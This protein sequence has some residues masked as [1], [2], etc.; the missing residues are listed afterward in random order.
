LLAREG[1]MPQVA[2][3]YQAERE[4]WRPQAPTMWQTIA[5]KLHP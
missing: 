3:A 2:K 1:M 5:A 4:Q